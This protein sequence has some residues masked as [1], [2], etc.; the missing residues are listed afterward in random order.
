MSEK[1]L[2]LVTGPTGFVGAHVFSALLTAGYRV[3]GTIRAVSKARYLQDKFAS[4]AG[5]FSFVVVPD[6]QAPGALD[7]KSVV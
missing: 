6:I 1:P 3:K 5:S 7:R 2:V 4:F